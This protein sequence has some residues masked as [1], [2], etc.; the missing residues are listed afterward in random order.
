MSCLLY[1]QLIPGHW[2]AVQYQ[3]SLSHSQR[4]QK[5]LQAAQQTSALMCA[6]CSG[7]VTCGKYNL[8]GRLAAY[9]STT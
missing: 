2:P 7:E 6:D 9:I 4:A 5:A 8:I 1:L 3:I